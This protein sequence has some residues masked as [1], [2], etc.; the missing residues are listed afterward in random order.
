MTRDAHIWDRFSIQATRHYGAADAYQVVFVLRNLTGRQSAG[1]PA[2]VILCADG[3]LVLQF[4]APDL[5]V[6][7]LGKDDYLKKAGEV[8]K[9]ILAKQ[10]P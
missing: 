6:P 2:A 10:K 7:G 4:Q 9:A 3:E 8:V 1:K 5:G